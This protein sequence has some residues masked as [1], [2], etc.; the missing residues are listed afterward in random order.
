MSIFN[1]LLEIK[2]WKKDL[3]LKAVFIPSSILW[4][5][6][7]Y[8]IY[9]YDELH[10]SFYINDLEKPG[11]SIRSSAINIIEQITNKAYKSEMNFYT[12]VLKRLQSNRIPN[13]FHMYKET[14]SDSIVI[15]KVDFEIIKCQKW[16]ISEFKVPN[17]NGT[18][19]SKFSNKNLSMLIWY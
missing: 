1:T 17:W 7:S 16:F 3:P 18:Q 4:E 8:Y 15:D 19:I 13:V 14:R 12:D 11:E 10:H 6:G 2:T 5:K 9:Y